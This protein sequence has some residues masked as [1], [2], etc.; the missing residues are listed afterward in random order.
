MLP[1]IDF[2]TTAAY[3]YLTDHFISINETDLKQL[4]TEDPDRFKKFSIIFQDT[5]FDFSKNRITDTTLALLVQL[6]KECKLDEAISAMFR[7]DK[8]NQT[9][10]REVLHVALRNQSNT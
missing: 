7:G 5:L 10:G 8:I 2:T 1:K 6:A 4:F 3:K 9:E